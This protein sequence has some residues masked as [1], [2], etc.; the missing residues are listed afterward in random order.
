[1][2]LQIYL[3]GNAPGGWVNPVIITTSSLPAA[4][5]GVSYSATLTAIGGSPPYT[6]Y[7]IEGALPTGLSLSSSGSITGI[8]TT[9]GTFSFRIQA[10]DPP[11]NSAVI[12]GGVSI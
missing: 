4:T 2:P 3:I 6:W 1:M 7:V 12:D 9:T 8:P 11:G 10:T 5:V